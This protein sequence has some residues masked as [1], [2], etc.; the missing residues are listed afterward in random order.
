MKLG[1]MAAIV[2]AILDLEFPFSNMG[3]FHPLL[4]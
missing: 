4:A 1:D 3:K 2:S